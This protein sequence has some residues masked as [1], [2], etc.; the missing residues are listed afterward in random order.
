MFF[1]FYP[2]DIDC[3]IIHLTGVK[4]ILSVRTNST[5]Y[6]CLKDGTYYVFSY[7]WIPLKSVFA[8]FVIKTLCKCIYILL[9]NT[10]YFHL[11]VSLF[12][13]IADTTIHTY[14][15][16]HFYQLYFIYLL[17]YSTDF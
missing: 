13:D 16:I 4:T 3:S 2:E 14:H 5:T 8:G 1:I 9:C 12:I 15:I 6:L 7:K 10:L 11:I 17:P